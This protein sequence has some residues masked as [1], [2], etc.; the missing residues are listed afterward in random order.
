MAC[1]KKK[2]VCGFVENHR[3]NYLKGEKEAGTVDWLLK[4]K[5]WI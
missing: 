2:K 3:I 5:R 1:L 4:Y